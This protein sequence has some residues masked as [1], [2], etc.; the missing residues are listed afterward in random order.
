MDRHFGGPTEA[1]LLI[2]IAAGLGEFMGKTHAATHSLKVA[3]ER[4]DE[5]EQTLASKEDEMSKLTAALQQAIL[6]QKGVAESLSRGG[7]RKNK[8]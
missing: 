3:E 1:A 5:L 7:S 4:I 8:F 2:E 6:E